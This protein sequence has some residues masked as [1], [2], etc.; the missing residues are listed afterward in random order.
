MRSVGKFVVA[1]SL[2]AGLADS[3]TGIFLIADPGLTLRFMGVD[4]IAGGEV[5]LRYIGVFVLGVGLAYFIGLNTIRKRNDWWEMRAIWKVTAILRLCVCLFTSIAIARGALGPGW[6][7]VPLTDGFFAFLQ[8]GF[9]LAGFWP[10][11]PRL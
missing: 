9:I 10:P 4:P 2:I 6:I 5:F 7:T 1:I 11:G 8:G 3:L